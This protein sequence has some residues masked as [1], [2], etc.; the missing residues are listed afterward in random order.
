MRNKEERREKEREREGMCNIIIYYI[1][2]IFNLIRVKQINVMQPYKE[3]EKN[4]CYIS[5]DI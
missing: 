4:F 3:K 2:K 1:S 5:T